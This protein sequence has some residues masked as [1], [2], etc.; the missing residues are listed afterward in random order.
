M[1]VCVQSRRESLLMKA[2]ERVARYE[3]WKRSGQKG[4][5]SHVLGFGSATPRDICQSYER[6]RRSSSHSALVRRSP[7]GSDSDYSF[8]PQRRAISACSTVRRHCCVDLN[9]TGRS[10]LTD[11]TP[12]PNPGLPLPLAVGAHLS[13]PPWGL[14][15]AK[16]C[17][18]F[19]FAPL[20]CCCEEEKERFRGDGVRCKCSG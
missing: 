9:R 5:R 18:P 1:C 11:S 16:G 15:S 19:L 3:A 14:G 7:N 2:E 13:A 17:A 8:R 10:S 20:L 4:G 12:T 6:P